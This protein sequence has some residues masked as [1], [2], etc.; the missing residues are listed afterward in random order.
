MWYQKTGINLIILSPLIESMGKLE[1]DS[2]LKREFEQI[3]K[4][5][6]SFSFNVVQQRI[7]RAVLVNGIA[8]LFYFTRFPTDM[9]PVNVFNSFL[10]AHPF[11]NIWL[12][13]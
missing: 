11:C 10:I 7:I 13:G 3:N 4:S 5:F 2:W 1:F 12:S 8:S 9:I 6:L